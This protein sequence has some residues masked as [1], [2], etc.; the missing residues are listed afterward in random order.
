VKPRKDNTRK[1]RNLKATTLRS[2]FAAEQF[3][4]VIPKGSLIRVDVL[5]GRDN[6]YSLKDVWELLVASNPTSSPF[7]SWRWLTSWI[8]TYGSGREIIT[9]VCRNQN[10]VV[11]IIPFSWKKKLSPFA[12]RKLWMVGFQS[13]LG[14]NGLT[15]EPIYVTKSQP[16]VRE[17]VL[18]AMHRKL[19]KMM[20][21]GPWDS[22]AYR[23]FGQGIEGCSL[24]EIVDRT[25]VVQKYMRGCETVNLSTTWDEYLKTLS[26]SMR[27]NIPYY[28]RRFE[29]AEIAIDVSVTPIEEISMSVDKMVALHKKRTY[30]DQDM[31]H[32]D[33]FADSRQVALLKVALTKMIPEGEAQLV[34]LKADGEVVAA[35]VFLRSEG[36]LLAHYSGFDPDWVKYSPLFVLQSE[37]IRDAIESGCRSL[38]L[39]RGNAQWQRRWGADSTNQIIDVT[40]AK[41]T[42]LPRFRQMIQSKEGTIQQVISE[43]KSIRVA[44]A[45]IHLRKISKKSA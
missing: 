31:I 14:T 42:A 4:Q 41:R 11:G 27:E 22:V 29:R 15:E 37:V 6:L 24:L 43:S 26:K 12:L 3:S 39:M 35:Q 33:Y 1:V 2:S 9:L 21:E 13:G 19:K 38:N 44:R 28:K 17:L 16:Q 25:I 20:S 23:K 32:V 8:E 34:T 7:V 10:E 40:I 5:V 18:S 36:M 45:K 30:S